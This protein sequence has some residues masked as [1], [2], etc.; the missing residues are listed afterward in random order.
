MEKQLKKP[1]VATTAPAFDPLA[2]LDPKELISLSDSGFQ[3]TVRKHARGKTALAMQTI[4]EVMT[5]SDDD[6]ARLIAATKILKIAKAEDEQSGTALPFGITE[7]V[8][9]I[10]LAGLGKLASIAGANLPSAVLRDVTPARSDPRPFIPD[11]SPLNRAIPVIPDFP[12]AD[13][14]ISIEE[15]AP[16][17]EE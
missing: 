10:A 17:E 12:D 8:L 11:D 3:E 2:Q 16:I 6:Q 4:Q 7:E 9:K 1:K 5:E 15:N 14:D 13:S